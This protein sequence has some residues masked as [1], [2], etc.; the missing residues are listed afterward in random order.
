MSAR[1]TDKTDV[2]AN[3]DDL[4]FPASAGVCFSQGYDIVF[5][6]IFHP[7]IINQ[8]IPAPNF[9]GLGIFSLKK[10]KNIVKLEKERREDNLLPFFS[11]V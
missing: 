10:N 2:R 7:L 6:Y 8:I 4:P 5:F 11:F 3:T 9:H 1:Q